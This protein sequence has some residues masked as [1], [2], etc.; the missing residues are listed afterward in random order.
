M[1]SNSEDN[2]ETRAKDIV[3]GGAGEMR[4]RSRNFDWS[5]T[6]LGPVATWPISLRTT[7][8]NIMGSRNPMFL[9]WGPDL[10]QIYNDG[11]RPSLGGDGRHLLALGARAIEFWTDIWEYIGP[12]IDQVMGGGEST[13]HEDQLIPIDRNNAREDVY[14]TYSYGPAFGDDGTVAG[15]LVVCQETTSQVI[16]RRQLAMERSRL[17]Y[18]FQQSP[19]FVCMLHGPPY[20]FDFVNTAFEN[21]IG[22]NRQLPGRLVFEVIPDAR[23]QGFEALLDGVVETGTPFVGREIPISL[24][25]TVGAPHEERLMDFVC[26]PMVELDGSRPGVLVHGVD[27]TEHVRAR[28]DIE[29]LLLASEVERN[30]ADAAR[31]EA[32]AAN[33]SKADFLTMLS[34]ELRT[35]LAA[36]GGYSELLQMG[37]QGPINEEQ[38][39]F[40]TRIQRSQEHLL[41]L[42]DGLLTFA[43][44][45]AGA[46]NYQFETLAVNEICESC[47]ELTAALAQAR[48]LELLYERSNST[49]VAY[50][51]REKVKQILL[52]LLSNAI[53]FTDARGRIAITISR[54]DKYNVQITVS[55]TGR[56]IAAGDLDRVFEPFVQVGE[57]A[58]SGTTGTGLGLAISRNLARGMRGDLTVESVLDAGSTFTLRLPSAG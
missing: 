8:M 51:D 27:I 55:D 12:Q 17:E 18:A 50:A 57:K 35:P 47:V 43:Q 45:D 36:I 52:N 24:A 38:K 32:D 20:V 3:F 16:A 11:Y 44:V 54:P 28:H 37:V 30:A 53:K 42:I 7:V 10:I 25:R 14:W 2:A 13:W 31:A 46:T 19:S 58:V 56:G 9:F 49:A 26:F 41:G 4:E 34:H 1:S 15:V 6:A 39:K 23:D 5:T 22:G 21:L 33:R 40:I 48:R 29:R